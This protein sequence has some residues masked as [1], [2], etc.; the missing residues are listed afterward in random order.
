MEKIKVIAENLPA[1]EEAVRQRLAQPIEIEIGRQYYTQ[2]FL[3]EEIGT[4]FKFTNIQGANAIE[5][6][7][8]PMIQAKVPDAK[9]IITIFDDFLIRSNELQKKAR[10]AL[11]G[12]PNLFDVDNILAIQLP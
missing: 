9:F 2:K 4:S 5:K 8:M 11:C 3:G 12:Q 1:F 7:L 10:V 6:Y